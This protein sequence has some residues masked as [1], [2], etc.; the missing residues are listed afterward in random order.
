MLMDKH[1]RGT[2]NPVPYSAVK[3]LSVNG[4]LVKHF[5]PVSV[6]FLPVLRNTVKDLLAAVA[7]QHIP[8]NRTLLFLA[9]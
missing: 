2:L 3:E 7:C 8:W 9:D 6:P 1:R 4:L 5:F